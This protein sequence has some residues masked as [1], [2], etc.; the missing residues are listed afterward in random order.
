MPKG[1]EGG[2]DVSPH[3]FPRWLEE[4]AGEIVRPWSF[5]RWER[6][7]NSQD[8]AFSESV[9]QVS[10][11]G[12]RQVKEIKIERAHPAS[13]HTQNVIEEVENNDGFLILDYQHLPLVIKGA[14]S[15]PL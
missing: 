3:N 7:N 11:I 15:V 2:H 10:Q 12:S 13:Q 8:F 6:P 14:D 4:V 5:V 9:T 1:I